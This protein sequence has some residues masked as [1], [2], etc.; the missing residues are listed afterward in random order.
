M[1]EGYAKLELVLLERAM[2]G[3]VKLVRTAGG[4]DREMREY[5][6]PLAV[7][8]LRRHADTAEEYGDDHDDQE[9]QETR[10]RILAKLERMRERDAGIE[11]KAAV[12]RIGLI[13]WGCRRV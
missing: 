2:K 1:R 4:S 11:T 12:D 10:E 7:A 6:T 8:L 5:S 9:L 3:T 13:H